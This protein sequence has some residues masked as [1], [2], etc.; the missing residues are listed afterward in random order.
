[1]FRNKYDVREYDNPKEIPDNAFNGEL[2]IK[3]P[4]FLSFNGSIRTHHTVI[5]F[6]SNPRVIIGTNGAKK[7]TYFIR[8][9]E[10]EVITE[11]GEP[12]PV[13]EN[14]N[15]FWIDNYLYHIPTQTKCHRPMEPHK[16]SYHRDLGIFILNKSTVIEWVGSRFNIHKEY[17]EKNEKMTEQKYADEVVRTPKSDMRERYDYEFFI[18]KLVNEINFINNKKEAQSFLEGN[19]FDHIPPMDLRD[20]LDKKFEKDELNKLREI[21]DR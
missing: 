3:K 5:E 21:K 16:V 2:E 4:H 8:N 10:A 6:K 13:A 20:E 19:L 18:D 17:N 11:R 14:K 7:A 15:F 9:G 12:R 1:M